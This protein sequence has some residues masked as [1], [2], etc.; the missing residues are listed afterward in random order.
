LGIDWRAA[1]A[2]ADRRDE[3]TGLRMAARSRVLGELSGGNIQRV[4]LT[5]ALGEPATVV[6]AAYPSRGL[7]IA[8]TRRTQELLVEQRD[9]GAAVLVVSEDL[10]ELLSVSDRIAVLHDGHLAGVVEPGS[11]DRYAI[12]RLMLGGVAA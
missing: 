10:D 5:R 1:G 9:A 3:A 4:V 8:T 12:G 2:E 11:T 6:V 7:D